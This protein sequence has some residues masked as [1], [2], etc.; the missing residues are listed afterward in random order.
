MELLLHR[1]QLAGS[2]LNMKI[3]LSLLCLF[4]LVACVGN[5]YEQF[6]NNTQIL[7]VGRDF[8]EL[9]NNRKIFNL[10]HDEVFDELQPDVGNIQMHK[11]LWG[12]WRG[13][14]C[15]LLVEVDKNSNKIIKVGA[16]GDLRACRW[17]G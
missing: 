4:P 10:A 17:G 2:N 12:S 15:Y 8:D 9:K 14:S 5:P 16:I 11:F 1:F 13:G 7:Y 3:L 6:L